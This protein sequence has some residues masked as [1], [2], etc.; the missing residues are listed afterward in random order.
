MLKF[1]SFSDHV[2]TS[3]LSEGCLICFI[4][5]YRYAL[6][7]DHYVL[8]VVKEGILTENS[9]SQRRIKSFRLSNA[10]QQIS[11]Q[12]KLLKGMHFWIF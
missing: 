9:A 5:W 4:E 7:P 11:K 1:K 12:R 2:L 6:K 8:I 10:L 3:V